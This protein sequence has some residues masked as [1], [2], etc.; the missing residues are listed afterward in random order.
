MAPITAE[1]NDTENT[2]TASGGPATMDRFEARR[3]L[4]ELLA[5]L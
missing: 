2:T 5:D 1:D 3:L 4:A